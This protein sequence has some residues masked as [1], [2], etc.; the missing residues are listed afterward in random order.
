MKVFQIRGK[1]L[2]EALRLARSDHGEDAL[3]LGKRPGQEGGVTL[4]VTRALSKRAK[5]REEGGFRQA[6][7]RVLPQS[8]VQTPRAE[9]QKEVAP[10]SAGALEVLDRLSKS[11]CSKPF[12]QRMS[13]AL[14]RSVGGLHPIDVA[15]RAIASGVDVAHSLKVAGAMRVIALVGPSGVGKTSCAVKL[16]RRLASSGRKVAL[17]TTD[18]RRVGTLETLRGYAEILELPLHVLREGARIQA[19]TFGSD[20][21]EVVLLDTPACSPIDAEEIEYVTG[22][23]RTGPR[24]ALE[25]YLVLSATT[26][27][28]SLKSIEQ[29]FARLRPAGCVLTKL[30]ETQAH[31]PV[32]EYAIRNKIGLAF[33]S[34][35]SGLESLHRATGELVGDLLLR[36]KLR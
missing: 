13:K 29:G 6:V 25:S 35:G 18:T 10:L 9:P 16:A 22:C 7:R 23:L 3:I 17:A 20:R 15:V 30:D 4:E 34:D 28:E 32:V 8:V 12:L 2:A 21:P 1:N 24:T 19:K 14:E 11:G 5:A 33:L 27:T 26:A 31:G 36:G